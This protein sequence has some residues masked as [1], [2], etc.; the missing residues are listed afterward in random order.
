MS[1]VR[2]GLDLTDDFFEL[3]RNVADEACG[4]D[5]DDLPDVSLLRQV[6]EVTFWAS[7]IPDEA[8]FHPFKV[9]LG[10]A[11]ASVSYAVLLKP[12]T[13]SPAELAKFALATRPRL[14]SVLVGR[15][16]EGPKIFGIDPVMTAA[17]QLDVRGPGKL[18]VKA[19]FD[20]VAVIS[21]GFAFL[22]ERMMYLPQLFLRG[23]PPNSSA[24]IRFSNIV[25]AMCDQG[26]GG[27]VL[28][29]PESGK[30]CPIL[31]IH[32]MFQHQYESHV[33]AQD[34]WNLATNR[35]VD[36]DSSQATRA[37]WRAQAEYWLSQSNRL[38]E[39]VGR[40]TAV[41]GALVLDPEGYVLGF[42]AKILPSSGDA[43]LISKVGIEVGSVA[44]VVSLSD[45]HGT[46]HQ[47]AARFVAETGGRA[48]VASQD[49]KLSIL[50]PGDGL[51][52]CV[53][54][55]EWLV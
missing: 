12:I 35:S 24:E 53:E 26:H 14:S 49:G 4:T 15:D 11:G 31:E 30:E 3:V 54:N 8:R 19:G 37:H 34:E 7:L 27:T 32:R 45:F 2:I 50:Y 48:F 47:S 6:V 55:A 33:K 9:S 1:S 25:A 16:A 22:V 5:D 41:D 43:P 36:R 51:V 46:R 20:A 40:T 52:E 13:L 18:A 42:A 21:N 39:V 44:V 10:S 23:A 28:V 29:L 38:A 17:V